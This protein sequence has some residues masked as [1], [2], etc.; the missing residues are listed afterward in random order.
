[1]RHIGPKAEPPAFDQQVAF[2]TR[3]RGRRH[4]LSSQEI[5]PDP[6]IVRFCLQRRLEMGDGRIAHSRLGRDIAKQMEKRG[7]I[8]RQVEQIAAGDLGGGKLAGGQRPCRK[9]QKL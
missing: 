9:V 8:R 7:I 1:M 4:A 5:F 6:F 3:W 2:T